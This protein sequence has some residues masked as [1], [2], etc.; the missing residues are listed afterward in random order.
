MTRKAKILSQ[1]DFKWRM[2]HLKDF[3]KAKQKQYFLC[4]CSSDVIFCVTELIQNFLK[5]KLNLKNIK[6]IAKKLSKIKDELK[7]LADSRISHK[8]K[9]EILIRKVVQK[10]LFPVLQKFFI[11]YVENCMKC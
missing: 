6:A 2:S 1:D 4:K 9:R 5:N 3:K 7:I 10:V 11:P 8:Q